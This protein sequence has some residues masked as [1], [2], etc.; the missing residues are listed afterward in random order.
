MAVTAIATIAGAQIYNAAISII[1]V[2]NSLISAIKK[3]N[4]AD[5]SNEVKILSAYQDQASIYTANI[6][7]FLIEQFNIQDEAERQ[8]RLL[9]KT[10]TLCLWLNALPDDEISLRDAIVHKLWGS[11]NLATLIEHD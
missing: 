10:Q 8:K 5:L 7:K 1:S 2:Q 11:V 6:L 9:A 4:V 3:E